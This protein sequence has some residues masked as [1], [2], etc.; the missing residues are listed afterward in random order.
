M[1]QMI[2]MNIAKIL[3]AG[4]LATVVFSGCGGPEIEPDWTVDVR[5]PASENGAPIVV[6]KPWEFEVLVETQGLA[7]LGTLKGQV[8]L[9]APNDGV[10]RTSSEV[11][12]QVTDDQAKTMQGKVKLT[13]PAAGSYVVEAEVGGIKTQS[14]VTLATPP[15]FLVVTNTAEPADALPPK[16]TPM[17]LLVRAMSGTDPGEPVSGLA[18]EVRTVPET[19]FL[20]LV[21]R[22]D[23]NGEARVHLVSP[24]EGSLIVEAAAHSA[25]DVLVLKAP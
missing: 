3:G 21:P 24:G 2:P 22:T 6:Q 7:L 12:L 15:L 5:F 8:R 13:A 23:R 9:L 4:L 14:E 18:L 16:G 10:T 20:P 11:V 19:K 17:E 1:R 25:S